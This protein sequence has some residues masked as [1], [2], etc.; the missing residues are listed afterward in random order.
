MEL[1]A[2]VDGTVVLGLVDADLVAVLDVV[3]YPAGD[4]LG[5]RIDIQHL[6]DVLV[7][8]SVLDHPFDVRE[9]RNHAVLIEFARLAIDDD[10][11]VV[12]VQGFAFALVREMEIV[13]SGN[14]QTLFYIIHFLGSNS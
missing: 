13:C 9:I 1:V 7:V 3:A 12:P 8:E 4:V 10:N 5:G 11:P 6:V 2:F 14:L